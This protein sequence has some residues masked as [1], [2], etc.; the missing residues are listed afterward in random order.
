MEK[1]AYQVEH[2]TTALAEKNYQSQTPQIVTVND[3]AAT[4]QAIISAIRHNGM[5]FIERSSW[6]AH[7]NKPEQMENDWNYSMI[8]LHHAGRS[9][10]CG[11]AALQLQD[12]QDGHMNNNMWPDIAYHYAI[13]CFGNVFE[14]RDIRFK[15]SHLYKYNTGAI[16][17]V[18]LE[19]LT[20]PGEGE[21][22]GSYITKALFSKPSVPEV[23]VDSTKK[24]IQVLK[25]FFSIRQLGGHREFPN[26]QKSDKI[27]PGN[28]GISLVNRLRKEL[29]ISAP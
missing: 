24:L 19:N 1:A 21:G 13:D 22:V 2:W 28:I 4:R 29:K 25:E 3:R 7:K 14:G 12:I 5:E 6:A 20:E 11:P 17:V 8:A 18:L 27:C 10:S 16:G 9:M 23:Q 15:G 26:Q